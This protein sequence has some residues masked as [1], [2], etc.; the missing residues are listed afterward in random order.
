MAKKFEYKTFIVWIDCQEEILVKRLKKIVI[1]IFLAGLDLQTKKTTFFSEAVGYKHNLDKK[2]LAEIKHYE[3][4]PI[5]ELLLE[6]YE[7]SHST[8]FYFKHQW[9]A[10][11]K[12]SY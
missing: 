12:C 7:I 4:T 2:A 10:I 6:I 1:K 9:Q 11:R 5:L 3:K 8:T